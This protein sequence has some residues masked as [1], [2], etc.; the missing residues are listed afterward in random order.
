MYLTIF[1]DLLGELCVR[2]PSV[3]VIVKMVD[4]VYYKSKF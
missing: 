4:S 2:V 1:F 3:K